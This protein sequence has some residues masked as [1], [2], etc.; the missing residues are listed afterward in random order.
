MSQDL[1]R[2]KGPHA[3]EKEITRTTKKNV[4]LPIAKK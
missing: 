2:K 3:Q 4:Q 1:R